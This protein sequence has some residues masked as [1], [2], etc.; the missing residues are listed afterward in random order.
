MG[1][2]LVVAG[3]VALAA[4]CHRL[5]TPEGNWL[6]ALRKPPQPVFGII[7]SVIGFRQ[8]LLH[9]LEK[10]RGEWSLVTMTWKIKRI[11]LAGPSH[12]TPSHPFPFDTLVTSLSPT[13]C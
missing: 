1:S 9:G 2:L 10:V 13:G 11:T 8:F 6:Y 7:K 5:A 12:M 4:M 3:D